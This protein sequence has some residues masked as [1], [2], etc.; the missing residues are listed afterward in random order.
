MVV[1]AKVSGGFA[2]AFQ[3]GLQGIVFEHESS[4]LLVCDAKNDRILKM[5]P[6]TGKIYFL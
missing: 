4:H 3:K 6:N 2:M 1:R 5:N